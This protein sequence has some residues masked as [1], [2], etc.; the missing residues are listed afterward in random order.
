MKTIKKLDLTHFFR[1]LI[2]AL[3][4][5]E[6][7]V[8]DVRP[9]TL[10]Q[11]KDQ[12][13]LPSGINADTAD[14]VT[15]LTS[16]VIVTRDRLDDTR[17]CVNS[18]LLHTPE[19]HEIIFV[20]NGSTDGTVKWIKKQI[21]AH[22]EYRLIENG[23]DVGFAKGWNQGLA[24]VRGEYILLLSNEVVVTAGWLAGMKEHLNSSPN[25]GIVGP[26]TNNI[27]GPQQV[28]E[29]DYRSSDDGLEDYASA[30]HKRNRHRRITRRRLMRFCMLFRKSMA[31][32]VGAFDERF[33]SGESEDDDYC[34]RSVLAGYVNYIAG[35]VFVHHNGQSRHR[36]EHGSDRRCFADKWNGIRLDT[37]LGG[38][39]FTLKVVED[40][41]QYLAQGE[42]RKALETLHYG[43]KVIPS[44]RYLHLVFAETLFKLERFQEAL[45]FLQQTQAGQADGMTFL[46]TGHALEE[47]G[48]LDE[49]DAL[50]EQVL[51]TEPISASAMNL[52]GKVAHKRGDGSSAGVW[53]QK[54]IAADPGFG[55]PYVNYGILEWASGRQTGALAL[56]ERGFILAPGDNRFA[57]AYHSAITAQEAWERGKK[58]F[59]EAHAIHPHDQKLVYLLIDIL[60]HKGED[61]AAM[62]MITEAMLAFGIDGLLKV[63]LEVRKKIGPHNSVLKGNKGG[64]SVCMIVKNEEKNLPRSL[65]CFRHLAQEII[66]VDTGSTDRT[67]EVALAFGA[68]VFEQTWENDF[69]KAR[70]YSLDQ[71][72]ADW[73]LV[74]DADEVIAPQDFGEIRKIVEKKKNH[75]TAWSMA[76]RN[77]LVSSNAF[78]WTANDGSY[79]REEGG[80]GWICS[81]KIRLFPNDTR[82][83]FE[84]RV[85]ELVETSIRKLNMSASLCPVPVHH[86]GGLDQ[87]HTVSKG[88][89][90]Y[91]LGK[92]KLEE[93]GENTDALREI[94]MQ[95]HLLKKFDEARYYWERY[96]LI[97]PN[98]VNAYLGLTAAFQEMHRFP[99]ALE[100]AMNGMAL[101][102]GSLNRDLVFNYAV[103]L[104]YHGQAAQAMSIL[105]DL[106]EREPDFPSVRSLSA[107]A[108]FCA[109]GDASA[110]EP[111]GPYLYKKN[112]EMDD[113]FL[114][115][116]GNLKAAGQARSADA[117]LKEAE[118][119]KDAS[120]TKK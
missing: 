28:P 32:K 87:S 82:I 108:A 14:T 71:A 120:G 89:I 66:V 75:N 29:S 86:Y 68:R 96:L 31:D 46:S 45:D 48:R 101:P 2:E 41:Q 11:V 37:P 7:A 43:I 38:N 52:K 15:D 39:L 42:A 117:I 26:M 56:I 55:E 4:G 70:N 18:I 16:L 77:Y 99:E 57:M 115:L 58:V 61:G 63:A 83:R 106:V 105:R 22:P 17:K 72:Q 107:V 95:A 8:S 118:N 9:S 92:K 65:M 85:H 3:A 19:T 103:C 24:A 112:G 5:A 98:F 54:A 59:S 40:A 53:Y 94:A 50:A 62:K 23:E 113:A 12:T 76:S 73:I 78:G 93:Q 80:S 88:E 51:L 49:A 100:A 79:P 30:F 67:R 97:D 64:V 44:S 110:L 119:W 84:N 33:R 1:P 6:P 116:I 91:E 74:M 21:N 90:Y 114:K 10:R 111:L 109:E 35:D 60:L 20:D 69:S 104:L 25:A 34:L 81:Y 36:A 102:E 47:L 13:A 27:S